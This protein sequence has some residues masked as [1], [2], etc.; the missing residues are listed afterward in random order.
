MLTQCKK[1]DVRYKMAALEATGCILHALKID[2]FS[3][4]FEV[5]LQCIKPVSVEGSL[6][7]VY[8]V[9]TEIFIWRKISPFSLPAFMGKIFVQRKLSA[10]RS[11]ILWYVYIALNTVE[12]EVLYRNIVYYS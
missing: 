9:Q 3:E 11:L 4:F 2:V 10:I 1:K 12:R 8:T 5:V 6:A 7:C